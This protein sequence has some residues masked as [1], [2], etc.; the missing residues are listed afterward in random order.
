M[1]L[2][3]SHPFLAAYF[4]LAVCGSSS[5]LSLN[6]AAVNTGKKDC[7]VGS[8]DLEVF[9]SHHHFMR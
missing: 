6:M 7:K 2:G 8:W 3:A 5:G 4:T 1:P 9:M